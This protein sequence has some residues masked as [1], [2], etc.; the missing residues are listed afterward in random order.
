[1]SPLLKLFHALLLALMMGTAFSSP[2]PE[3]TSETDLE[4]RIT[5]NDATY[6][7]CV[8]AD[9]RCAFYATYTNG[10]T[11][12]TVKWTSGNRGSNAQV[13]ESNQDLCVYEGYRKHTNNDGFWF[14]ADLTKKTIG[15]NPTGKQIKLGGASWKSTD[16]NYINGRCFNEFGNDYKIVATDY[17]SA[18]LTWNNLGQKLY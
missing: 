17:G 2:V 1:M 8:T 6:L 3:A 7:L 9:Y 11:R 15:Y 5:G 10:Q 14:N 16:P 12:E 18:E 13:A 4:K